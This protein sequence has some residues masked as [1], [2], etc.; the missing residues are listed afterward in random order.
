MQILETRSDIEQLKVELNNTWSRRLRLITDQCG[1]YL[2]KNQLNV[3][4]EK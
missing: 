4:G 2:K 3:H 1:L